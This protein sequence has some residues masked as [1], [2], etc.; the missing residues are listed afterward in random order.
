MYKF[1]DLKNLTARMI[2]PECTRDDYSNCHKFIDTENGL[3]KCSTPNWSNECPVDQGPTLLFKFCMTNS[4]QFKRKHRRCQKNQKK[5]EHK[6]KHF[7]TKRMF[8]K[9]RSTY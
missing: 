6:S 1:N 2:S 7:F 9:H 8:D 4:T 3:V 5:R